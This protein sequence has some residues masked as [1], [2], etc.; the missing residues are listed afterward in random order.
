[1][2]ASNITKSYADRAVLEGVSFVVNAGECAGVVA[3]NGAGKTTLLR[4]LAGELHPD[5]GSVETGGRAA[6]AYVRQGFADAAGRSVAEVFPALFRALGASARIEETAGALATASGRDALV[7]AQRA[8]DDAMKDA[9]M[10]AGA[11]AAGWQELALRAIS[12]DEPVSSLSGGEQTK[13]ALLDAFSSRPDVLLL[14]E[15]TN[16]L[17]MQAAQWLTECL[18]AFEGAIV[19]VSHDRALLDE[20]ADFIVELDQRTGRATVFSGGYTDYATEKVRRRDAQWTAF[21]RQQDRERRVR[22]EIRDIKGTAMRREKSS[23]NDFYRRKAKKVARRAVVLERRLERELDSD[24]RVVKPMMREYRLKAEI[25]PST[26]G[27]DRML[28]VE[29]VAVAVGG[30][31]LVTGASFQLGWGERAVI[32]GPNGGGKTTLLR[33]IVGEETPAAGSIVRGPSVKIGYLAQDERLEA[34]SAVGET[35]VSLL[36]AT[37][38]LSETE[39]RRFLHR[40]LFQGDGVH[41]PIASLSYGERRR[42]SL[43]MLVLGCANLLVLDEPTNHLDIPSRE[44]L[45]AALDSYDGAI[46]AVTHD[47]YFIDRF[48]QRLLALEGGR[49]REVW[50]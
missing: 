23:Q 5:S 48:A 1:M 13:L 10:D 38:P 6:V 50:A 18:D 34:M 22:R 46:L 9:G 32:I 16:N 29:E 31:V 30:R 36:R 14:D 27:G 35:P 12:A 8:Y 21:R 11:L 25:R 2:K 41:T 28:A 49:L 43:A 39:A 7:A 40:F 47:R 33:A 42:L 20:Y 19:L 15:P 37:A 3:P 45:E 24:E 17:D 4:I 44:A 26:R